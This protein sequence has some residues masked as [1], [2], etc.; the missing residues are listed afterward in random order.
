MVVT[1]TAT[2]TITSATNF[3]EIPLPK[4]CALFLTEVEYIRALGRGKGFRRSKQ[5]RERILK[6]INKEEEN[7]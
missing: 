7:R 1:A 2:A 5:L 4:G 6:K 3:I